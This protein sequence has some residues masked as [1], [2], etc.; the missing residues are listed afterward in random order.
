M[1]T[2][3]QFSRGVANFFDEEVRPSLSGGKA[4]LYGIIVGRAA[5]GMPQLIEQYAAILAPLGILRDGMIDAEGLAAELKSQMQKNGGELTVPIKMLND[6]F[7]F[8][9]GDVDTLMRCIERA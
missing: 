5:A 9:M 3:E 2:V 6:T 4:I 7:T 8:R 1:K